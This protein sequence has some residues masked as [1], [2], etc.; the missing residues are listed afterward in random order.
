[1]KETAKF[2]AANNVAKL[3]RQYLNS[4]H[5]ELYNFVFSNKSFHRKKDNLFF[6]KV[7]NT[8]Q[9]HDLICYK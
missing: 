5:L 7:K 9:L 3:K 4:N 6:R 1:M 8:E 2:N